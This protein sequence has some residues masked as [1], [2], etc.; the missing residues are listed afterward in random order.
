M[1]PVAMRASRRRVYLAGSAWQLS[2]TTT[3]RSGQRDAR[4]RQDWTLHVRHT[5]E[6]RASS[7]RVSSSIK[8]VTTTAKWVSVMVTHMNVSLRDI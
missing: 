4:I 2:A 5:A 3:L 7:S 6:L 1:L 8:A